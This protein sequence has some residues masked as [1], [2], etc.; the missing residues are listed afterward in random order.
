MKQMRYTLAYMSDRLKRVLLIIG[1]IFVCIGLGIAI[2]WTFFRSTSTPLVPDL[3]PSAT[4]NLPSA[5]GATSGTNA[6]IP[7]RTDGTLPTSGSLPPPLILPSSP[8]PGTASRTQVVSESITR[9]LAPA[10]AAG[11]GVRYYN[12]IDGRFYR[13][14]EDGSQIPLSDQTFFNVDTVSWGNTTDKAILSFPDG[15]HIYYDFATNRQTTLPKQWEEFAFSPDDSQIASK[16]IGNNEDNRFLITANPD[17]TNAKAIE[18]LGQNQDLVHVSWSP[19]N[20]TIAY[21]FTGEP[22]GFDRQAVVMVGKN[23]ENFKNLIVEGRGFQPNWSPSGQNILY[24]VYSGSDGFRPGLWV[25]GG[26]GD[27]MNAN[28]RNL[29]LATWANKCAWQS[30]AVLY[31]AVP[32]SLGQG[33]GLQPDLF[34]NTQDFIYKVDLL[35]GALTNLGQPDGAPSVNQLTIG[36]D[37]KSIYFNDAASGKLLRFS[38]E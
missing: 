15:A 23:H 21:A 14:A 25:S 11:S 19:N 20:Q 13:V 2:Y 12:P 35:S 36:S 6:G 29:G 10:K 32:A 33:A 5:G 31:C 27:A 26:V 18:P 37:G 16:S 24:S 30:E 3:G 34:T 1:F 22:I 4:G 8:E 9:A 38:V 7:P 17:G 28:R